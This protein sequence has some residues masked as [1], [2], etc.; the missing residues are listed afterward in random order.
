MTL[1]EKQMID[2][3]CKRIKDK[4]EAGEKISA[5]DLE[6]IATYAWVGFIE[7]LHDV[8]APLHLLVRD[9]SV[10]HLQCVSDQNRKISECDVLHFINV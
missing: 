1:S 7:V 2:A 6:A 9:G 8:A 10:G 4:S 5:A 3:A